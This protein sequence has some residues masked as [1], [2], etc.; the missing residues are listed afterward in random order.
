MDT[1][2]FTASRRG[3]L[4]CITLLCLGLGTVVAASPGGYNMSL[5]SLND[6]VGGLGC[7]VCA[8]LFQALAVALHF[9]KQR[10]DEASA[11]A[12]P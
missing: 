12:E 9:F 11:G 10:Y 8:I 4:T 5:V 6:S 3:S 7:A 1:G 2:A